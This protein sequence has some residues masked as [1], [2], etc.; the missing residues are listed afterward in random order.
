M[1]T[2]HASSKQKAIELACKKMKMNAKTM[3]RQWGDGAFYG[4][5]APA[6]NQQPSVTG[7]TTAGDSIQTAS[8]QSQRCTLQHDE[9]A[10]IRPAPR[11]IKRRKYTSETMP[12]GMLNGQRPQP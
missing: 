6:L 5:E 2:G 3:I 4:V 12:P 9:L 7:A 8:P 10:A 1:D 11:M